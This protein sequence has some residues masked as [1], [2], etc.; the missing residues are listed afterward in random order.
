MAIYLFYKSWLRSFKLTLTTKMLTTLVGRRLYFA[1]LLQETAA[2][3][4]AGISAPCLQY[5]HSQG[6]KLN[7]ITRSQ[8]TLLHQVIPELCTTVF[9]ISGFVCCKHGQLGLFDWQWSFV[10]KECCCMGWVSSFDLCCKGLYSSVGF[11][12]E[13]CEQHHPHI[14]NWPTA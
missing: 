10:P 6:A 8:Q 9:I 3:L 14:W 12:F 11:T 1:D 4:T 5:L 2:Y 7:V 13:E